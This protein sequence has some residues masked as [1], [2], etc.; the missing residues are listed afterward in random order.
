MVRIIDILLQALLWAVFLR[1]VL[2]WFNIRRDNPIYPLLSVLDQVTEP[3]LAPLRRVVPR[4]GMFDLTPMVAIFI[5]YL[6]GVMVR[7]FL[8]Y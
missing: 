5:L 4:A 8:H 3:I 1:V 7:T 6:L 2:S